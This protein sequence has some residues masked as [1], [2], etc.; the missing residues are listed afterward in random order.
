MTV[1]SDW[2]PGETGI[3]G[4]AALRSSLPATIRAWLKR[5]GQG[6]ARR[7]LTDCVHWLVRELGAEIGIQHRHSASMRNRNALR[8]E[9]SSVTAVTCVDAQRLIILSKRL[10]HRSV[11]FFG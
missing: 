10:F 9:L 5:R 4:I 1:V 2:P 6:H 3:A 11:I 8:K 7:Q